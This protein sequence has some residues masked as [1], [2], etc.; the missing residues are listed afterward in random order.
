MA[1]NSCEWLRAMRH[2]FSFDDG[3]G[4]IWLDGALVPVL[5][6]R[7]HCLTPSLHRGDA[8][9]EGIRAYGGE[10][11]LGDA[12][13]ER[14]ARS[15]SAMGYAI[16]RSPIELAKAAEAV[17]WAN[18]LKDACIRAI[19]WRGSENLSATDSDGN[20]HMAIAA[21]HQPAPAAQ[22]ERGVRLHLSLWR[23]PHPE[24]APIAARCAGLELIGA[25]ARRAAR[26]A[27]FDDALLLD[28]QDQ[29]AAP[30]TGNIVLVDRQ[31]LVSP[32]A[33]CFLDS[34]A[35]RHVFALARKRGLAVVERKVSL[36]DLRAADEVFMVGTT[37]EVAPIVALENG[38]CRARWAV[39][40]VT[41]DL[42]DDFR[43]S[44]G[45]RIPVSSRFKITGF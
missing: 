37:E 36:A 39:G 34:I 8:I 9:F 10:L 27:G 41:R 2:M 35:K 43:A 7:I 1:L 12:H 45:V 23:R 14:L 15:A 33:D 30:T 17:L 26:D 22:G 18:E 42:A 20:I 32:V 13:F 3:D 11:F 6:A 40:P 5:E 28:L 25:L 24:T 31:T 44:T 21:W 29:V 4:L 19:A 38:A 16:P